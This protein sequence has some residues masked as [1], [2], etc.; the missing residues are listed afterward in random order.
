MRQE[1]FDKDYEELGYGEPG[2]GPPPVEISIR[3]SSIRNV[4]EAS[5]AETAKIR[6]EVHNGDGALT[7]YDVDYLKE[8]FGLK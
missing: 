7:D 2:T 1:F 5:D 4:L 8:V 3:E 6:I